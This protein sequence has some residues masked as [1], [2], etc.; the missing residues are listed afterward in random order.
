MS[1]FKW[2]LVDQAGVQTYKMF[3]HHDTYEVN[4]KRFSSEKLRSLF[5]SDEYQRYMLGKISEKEFV[6]ATINGQNLNFEEF[7]ELEKKSTEQIKGIR[8]ILENLKKKYKLASLI[9]EGKEIAEYKFFIS[10]FRELF[11]YVITSGELHLKKPDLK[12]FKKSLEIIEAEPEECFFIDDEQENVES[13]KKLGIEAIVFENV[14][15]LKKE[16]LSKRIL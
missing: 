5:L 4:N 11:D 14:H 6:L 16:L 7:I 15:Q 2:I 1:K 10:E 3:R 13:A 12:F 9:N 8:E